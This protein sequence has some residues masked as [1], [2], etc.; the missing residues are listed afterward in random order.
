MLKLMFIK[1]GGQLGKI[2]IPYDEKNNTCIISHRKQRKGNNSMKLY[3]ID[4]A[5]AGV[6][7]DGL[8]IDEETGEVLF[9][10][11]GFDQLD[12][13]RSDKMEAVGIFIKGLASDAAELRSEEK[14][15]AER[16]KSKE[17]KAER[18]KAYLL[19]SMQCLGDKKFETSRVAV[20]IRKSDVTV[21]DEP[22]AIPARYVKEKIERQPDK[23]AIKKAIKAGEEI[24]GAHIETRENL[25]VK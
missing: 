4:R 25:G 2:E 17:K 21:I 9:D 1:K 22:D 14:A 7:E 15:L 11:D 6:L 19:R 12:A 20:I 10:E 18:L 8:V 3:E 16:R 13:A 23:A 24:R 5:I